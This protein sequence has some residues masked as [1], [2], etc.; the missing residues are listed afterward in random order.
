MRLQTLRSLLD[1][2]QV[3]Y[4]VVFVTSR[5]NLHCPFCFVPKKTGVGKREL[6][7]EEFEQVARKVGPLVQLSLTGGEPFLREDLP[8][9]ARAF[10]AR[11][12]LA[13]T[14]APY[15]TVPTN[16]W[17]TGRI[18]DFLAEVLPLHP[19]SFFRIALSIDALGQ[20][21]DRLRGQ[22][23]TFDH[24]LE[25]CQALARLRQRFPNLVVDANAVFHAANQ[26]S[27]EETLQHLQECFSFD[28]LSVTW[29]RGE[30][31]DPSLRPDSLEKY[32]AVLRR[33]DQGPKR[34]EK[35]AFYPVWR[36]VAQATRESVARVL[37]GGPPLAPCVAGRKLVVLRQDGEVFPC[38]V[39]A[40]SLGNLLQH[41]GDLRSLL[42]RPAARE[43]TRFLRESRC[44]CTYECAQSANVVW[45]PRLW[46]GLVRAILR[47][48]GVPFP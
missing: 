40:R 17:L 9:L 28:N 41:E 7:L 10:L 15:V 14:G 18:V 20:E 35:R 27:L 46:P 4:L 37:R 43:V 16:G 30:L 29:A 6:T 3:G 42:A 21:H 24:L 2:G 48:L 36:G 32:E 8:S 31:A 12:F 33:L 34:W 19:R 44:S 11:A 26:D 5:C 45:S 23:G 25:T 47:N 22:P 39:L 13:H 1:P 38:E